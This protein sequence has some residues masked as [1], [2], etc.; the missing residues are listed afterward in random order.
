MRSQRAS[1]RWRD[2][3]EE[4]GLQESEGAS[5]LA[6]RIRLRG[7]ASLCAK[8]HVGSSSHCAVVPRKTPMHPHILLPQKVHSGSH[9]QRGLPVSPK[10]VP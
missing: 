6:P 3:R 9:G 10:P 5:A 7:L 2:K 8:W 1:R 4:R